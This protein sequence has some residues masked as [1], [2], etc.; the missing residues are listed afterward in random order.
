MA[1][2]RTRAGAL[3]QCAALVSWDARRLVDVLALTERQ[4]DEAAASLGA[5]AA[6]LGPA[7]RVDDIEQSLVSHL[8]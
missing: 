4:R 2:R 1:Q 8:P 3:F 5:V 7:V 6:G